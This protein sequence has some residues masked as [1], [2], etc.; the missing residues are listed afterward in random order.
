MIWLDRD[1]QWSGIATGKRGRRPTFS[2]AAIQF[3]LT[4]KG[5]F[6]LALGQA[7][8]MVES[9]LKLAPTTARSVRQRRHWCP[10]MSWRVRRPVPDGCWP[11]ALSGADY[12][13]GSWRISRRAR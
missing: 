2:D 10:S 3:C 12:D 1:L 11:C 5:L 9:L 13:S 6:S 8:G 7:M 4:I